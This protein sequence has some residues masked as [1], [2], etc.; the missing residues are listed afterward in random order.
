M[1]LTAQNLVMT[2]FTD[3]ITLSESYGPTVIF[4]FGEV[5]S[6]NTTTSGNMTQF[7][8]GAVIPDPSQT[9]NSQSI[10]QEA[11]AQAKLNGVVLAVAMAQA[12]STAVADPNLSILGQVNVALGPAPVPAAY[13]LLNYI[14][15]PTLLS[16]FS[17]RPG[18]YAIDVQNPLTGTYGVN[19]S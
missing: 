15:S 3:P 13:A 1:E 6:G 4:L 17:A 2:S 9:N 8:T 14:G 12:N 18:Q 10:V 7:V 11:V 5:V 16:N 19:P